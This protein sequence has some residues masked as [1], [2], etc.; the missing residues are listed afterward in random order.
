MSFPNVTAVVYS[1]CSVHRLENE[2]V[3][4]AA[5]KSEVIACM[6]KMCMREIALSAPKVRGDACLLP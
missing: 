4:D 6:R 2:D 5:L 1:T 3:V